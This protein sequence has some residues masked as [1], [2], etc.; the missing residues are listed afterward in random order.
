MKADFE[1]TLHRKTVQELQLIS[2]DT[3]FYSEDERYLAMDELEKRGELPDDLADIKNGLDNY[4][5]R[6]P[7]MSHVPT[8]QIYNSKM[9]WVG[10]YLGGPLVAGYI[11]AANFRAFDDAGRAK[12]AW[13]YAIIATVVIFTTITIL[14]Y[15]IIDKIPNYVIPL[16][17]IGIAAL[18]MNKYQG[19]NIGTHLASGGPTFSWGML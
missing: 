11:I 18:L 1:E 4:E 7:V 2:K 12:K 9:L 19:H 15:E 6:Y 14:P 16:T 5:Q 13:I 17:Y 10:T 3:A 8:Q